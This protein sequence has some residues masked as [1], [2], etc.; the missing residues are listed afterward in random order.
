MTQQNLIEVDCYLGQFKSATLKDKEFT[1][2]APIFHNIAK[3]K[4]KMDAPNC[5]HLQA[6]GQLLIYVADALSTSIRYL[7][8]HVNFTVPS[9]KFHMLYLKG[10]QKMCQKLEFAFKL[11]FCP[12]Q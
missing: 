11:K 12:D 8:F 2:N 5:S 10:K 7:W 3:K 4:K 1:M 9:I 6:N